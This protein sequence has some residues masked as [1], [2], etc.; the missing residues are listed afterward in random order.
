MTTTVPLVNSA[1]NLVGFGQAT[2]GGGV[3]P[4]TDPAYAKVTTPLD[5]ANAVL[6]FNKT[7]GVK[8]IEIMNDLDLGWNEIGSA[9]QT[10]A[11]TPFTP[12]PRRNC[13][14]D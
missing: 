8:V 4:D 1:Y 10:L 7:G 5:L 9:V 2:T 11:S 13:T 3:I 14:R 6:A 12:P